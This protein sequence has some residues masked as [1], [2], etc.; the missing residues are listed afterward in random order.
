MVWGVSAN[1][2]WYIFATSLRNSEPLKQVQISHCLQIIFYLVVVL[3][4]T[5]AYWGVDLADCLSN[6]FEVV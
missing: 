4:Y 3:G 2:Y 6:S 5:A 1:A